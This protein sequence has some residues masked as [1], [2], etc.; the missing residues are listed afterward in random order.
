MCDLSVPF[1]A[2]DATRVHQTRSM[3]HTGR[4][5]RGRRRRVAAED[6]RTGEPSRGSPTAALAEPRAPNAVDEDE[7]RRHDP[8]ERQARREGLYR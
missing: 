8:R 4:D 7:H 5:V 2:I 1:H 6:E 3:S